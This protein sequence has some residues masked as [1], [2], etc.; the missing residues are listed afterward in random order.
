MDP[1]SFLFRLKV[2]PDRDT[3]ISLRSRT[4][5]LEGSVAGANRLAYCSTGRKP[6][7]VTFRGPNTGENRANTRMKNGGFGSV[8]PTQTKR[9]LHEFPTDLDETNT[10]S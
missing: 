9:Y 3:C 8:V 10:N 4:A 2:L 7:K 6:A 5:T 1:G